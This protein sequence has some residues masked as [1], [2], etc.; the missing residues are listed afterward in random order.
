MREMSEMGCG[1]TGL[2]LLMPFVRTVDTNFHA[3]VNCQISNCSDKLL[4]HFSIDWYNIV[5]YALT[6]NTVPRPANIGHKT[7]LFTQ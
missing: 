5:T 2:H 3:G 7:C 1:L 4:I 6:E